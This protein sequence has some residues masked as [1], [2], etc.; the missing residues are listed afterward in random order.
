MFLKIICL[1][2]RV[3]NTH[4]KLYIDMWLEKLNK[5]FW[6]IAWCVILYRIYKC[7]FLLQFEN[8]WL[9]FLAYMGADSQKFLVSGTEQN[10]LH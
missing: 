7:L 2:A 5:I 1:Q 8:I 4:G 10:T 3:N 6:R 9:H